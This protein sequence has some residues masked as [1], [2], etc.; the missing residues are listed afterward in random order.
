MLSRYNV[1]P[2]LHVRPFPLIVGAAALLLLLVVGAAPGLA[3][4]VEVEGTVV[5]A[6]EGMPLPGV[7]I[8]EEGTQ[9]GTTTNPNGE[10]TLT[11][12]DPQATLVF[13]FV[14]FQ[15]KSVP[16]EGRSELTIE[17]EEE[18][19]ALEGVVVTAF[20]I[21]QQRRGL[22]YSVEQVDGSELAEARTNN[23]GESLQGLISGVNVEAPPTGPGGSTRITIRGNANLAGN[24]P[25]FVVDGV[26]IR[27][28]QEGNAS[29]WG[30]FDGGDALSKLNPEDIE[31]ISVLK[32]A[33]AAAL[34]GSRAQN[35]VVLIQ[36]K[37]GD[38]RAGETFSVDYTGSIQAETLTSVFDQFQYEYGQGTQGEAPQTQQDALDTSQSSWGARIDAVDQAMQFDGEMR[39]YVAQRDNLENFYDT[40]V[41][42]EHSIAIA[43]G[44]SEYD[45]RMSLSRMDDGYITPATNVERTTMNLR[46]A[47]EVG[48]LFMD[49]KLNY[50]IE[51]AQFRPE[52]SDNPANPML[53]LTFMPTTLD[54][55]TLDPHKTEDGSHRAWSTSPFRPNPYWGMREFRRDDDQRRLQGFALARYRFTDQISLQAR[56]GTDYYVLD[57]T[58]AEPSG[59]PWFQPGRITESNTRRREDNANLLLQANQDLTPDLGLDLTLGGNIRYEQNELVSANGQD[60]ILPN[61]LTLGNTRGDQQGGGYGFSEKQ[62]NSAFGA[63][64]FNY[65][66]YL[67]L[68]LTGRND[69]SST[70]PEDNNS[71]FYP[72]VNSSFI[73]TEVFDGLPDVLSNG[74]L[75]AAWGRVGADTNPYQLNVTYGLVGSHPS[76]EGGS[77][78][79]GSLTQTTIPPLDLKPEQKETIEFGTGLQFFN[80]RLGLDATW[81]RESSFNQ[82]LSV[83]VSNTTGFTGRRI[84]AGNIRN[85]GLE[86]QLNGTILQGSDLS[87]SSRANFTRNVNEVVELADQVDSFTLGESRS[88]IVTIQARPGEPYGQIVG[89]TFSR[90]ESG[91]I[92]FDE[93]GLPVPGE[94]QAIGNQERSWQAGWTNTLRWK[95][96]VLNALIDMSWGG[97]I[98]SFTNAQAY[99]TGRHVDTLPGRELGYVVGDGVIVT[100]RNEDGDIVS[101]RPNDVAVEPQ[102]YYGFIGGNIAEPFVYDASY[103][104]L[105]QVRLSYNLPQSVLN[106]A[107]LPI[108]SA[109]IA[110][111][112][113]NTWL[114]YD[115]V[116]NVDPSASYTTGNDHGLEHAS[117]P[118]TRTFGMDL[119]LRF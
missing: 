32:G 99:G 58:F 46:G 102:T 7:N 52:L 75:R 118:A 110:L 96:F 95:N 101:T 50:T 11:V 91:E 88:R 67:Y 40:G 37:G 54:V 30:G 16:L 111:T 8:V 53:S 20:G 116:P 115:D 109:Q 73:F 70:L 22:G 76:K 51:G 15:Q 27:N 107:S 2:H 89:P 64:R 1:L 117:L 21:E 106:V 87:W 4:N 86:L 45:V 24:N 31:S 17:L 98:Y 61:L 92:I 112:S 72:S 62:V 114:I 13:T 56:I 29:L 83:G 77:I 6:T 10:F 19:Q 100:E 93:D 79:R 84:N 71:Y 119:R 43:R 82:I 97:D 59:T 49:G 36:T 113:R 90:T 14:G 66:D 38:V 74:S 94:N 63:A 55:R 60:F 48:N 42:Q 65:R 5:D 9:N 39:P 23:L 33:S 25:L 103:I 78:A 85:Q 12:S 57:R 44:G 35:G 41:R 68:E 26:P 104:R 80:G 28:V 81:Y 18:V 34:Y 3:Q 69:W 105:R 47:G 108:Q